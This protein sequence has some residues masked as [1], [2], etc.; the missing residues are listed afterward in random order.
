MVLIGAGNLEVSLPSFRHG[1]EAIYGSFSAN[2]ATKGF[3]EACLKSAFQ[4]SKPL[5]IAKEW[6]LQWKGVL[7]IMGRYFQ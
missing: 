2:F 6:E 4:K 7:T 3:S 1:W 5:L